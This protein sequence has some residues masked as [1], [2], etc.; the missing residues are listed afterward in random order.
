[1]LNISEKYMIYR[2]TQVVM[3]ICFD[4]E[5]EAIDYIQNTRV[6]PVEWRVTRVKDF[7]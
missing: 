5:D 2:G 3:T 6:C 7:F 4:T 1:M